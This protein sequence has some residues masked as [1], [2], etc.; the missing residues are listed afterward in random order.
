MKSFFLSIITALSA[1]FGFHSH[2]VAPSAGI[3]MATTSVTAE[4]VSVVPKPSPMP[5]PVPPVIT[6]PLGS[7][8]LQAGQTYHITWQNKDPNPIN[9]SVN[10]E[11]VAN[12]NYYSIMSLGVV[13]SAQQTLAFAVPS[14][15]PP[16]TNYQIYFSD[17]AHKSDV[18]V[19]SQAFTIK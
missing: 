12:G 2:S 10:L 13:S 18:I 17:A 5:L 7:D 4:T 15:T 6:Y 19:G 1:L 14:S 9:Y 3:P 16:K 8:V 11:F